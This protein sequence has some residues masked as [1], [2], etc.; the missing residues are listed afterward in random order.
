MDKKDLMIKKFLSEGKAEIGKDCF[1]QNVLLSLPQRRSSKSWLVIIGL[2]K[3][4]LYLTVIALIFYF[5]EYNV[6]AKL[7]NFV[8]AGYKSA[9]ETIETYKEAILLLYLYFAGLSIAAI[10]SALIISHQHK[11]NETISGVA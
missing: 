2:V 3:L 9:I 5:A 4:I 6:W 1:T 11:N 8:Q 7:Y 10:I